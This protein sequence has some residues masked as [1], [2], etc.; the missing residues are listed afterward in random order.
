[1][2][3]AGN[4]YIVLGAGISGRAATRWLLQRAARVLL[5]DDDASCLAAV[6]AQP[7]LTATSVAAQVQQ[8]LPHS[9]ALVVSPGVR[10]EHPLLVAARERGVNICSEVELGLQA[11]RGRIAAV[12]GTNGKSTVAALLHHLLQ[13]LPHTSALCGNIGTAVTEVLLSTPA[14]ELLVVELSSFQLEHTQLPELEVAIFTN[15]TPSH[16][17][18]HGNA[19]T[20]FAMKQRIFAALAQDGCGICDAQVYQRL[21]AVPDR[22]LVVGETADS[23]PQNFFRLS[24]TRVLRAAELICDCQPLPSHAP[25]DVCNAAMALLAAQQ[26]SGVAPAQ[27]VSH[28]R[29]WRGLPYRL[30]LRGYLDGQAV[31]NDSKAT[32]LD[33]TLAA[34]HAQTQP[35]LLI[36][37]GEEKLAPLLAQRSKLAAVLVFGEAGA[38]LAAQLQTCCEVMQFVDLAAVLQW[39]QRH[40]LRT[41]LLFSPA[42]VSKPEFANFSQRGEF[43]DTALRKLGERF[44]AVQAPGID[45]GKG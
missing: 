32:N 24:G 11:Y 19:A 3:V 1:M 5:Y 22:L 30:Q 21:T 33:S 37:G 8:T 15:F 35:V 39:L 23:T 41:P 12:T 6:P 43:F 2:S 4:T 42:C 28:L 34:L 13:Q 44:R 31:I 26:L 9:R 27:L 40:R 18:R 14:P 20:Y 38:A 16:L 7:N 25:H 17:A 36:L 10:N 45:G 29:S